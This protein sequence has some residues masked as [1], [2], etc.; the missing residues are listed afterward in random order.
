VEGKKMGSKKEDTA[1]H[2]K[3]LNP[4]FLFRSSE[5]KIA[6]RPWNLEVIQ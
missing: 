3:K 1:Y 6:K 2:E 4:S 5:Q